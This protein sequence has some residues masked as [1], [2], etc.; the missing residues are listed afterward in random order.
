MFYSYTLDA[1]CIERIEATKSRDFHVFTVEL[2]L[3]ISVMAACPGSMSLTAT[4]WP[5]IRMDL[6]HWQQLHV[7]RSWG[8]TGCFGH[9]W[10]EGLRSWGVFQIKTVWKRFSTKHC[11]YC[12][13]WGKCKK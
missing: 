12:R 10:V 5:I 6:C 9:C 7:Q 2:A 13:A 4:P 8:I 11:K 1:T 3:S